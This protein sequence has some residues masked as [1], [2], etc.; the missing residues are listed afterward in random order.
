MEPHRR[1]TRNSK[2]SGNARVQGLASMPLFPSDR[3]IAT[4]LYG[5]DRKAAEAFL[6][7]I[8]YLE[9]DGFPRA[10]AVYGRRYWPAVKAYLDARLGVRTESLPQAEDGVEVW[11]E[12]TKR[13]AR[14]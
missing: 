13:R 5:A 14:A 6:T 4:A 2:M 9:N 11:D 3:E 1:A 7:R 12:Q 10:S 8:P